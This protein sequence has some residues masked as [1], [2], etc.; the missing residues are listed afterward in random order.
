MNEHIERE[1]DYTKSY[2]RDIKRY[3][4]LSDVEEYNLGIAKDRGDA[5]ALDRFVRSNLKLVVNIARNYISS[6]M[7]LMDLVQEGNIGLLRAAQKYDYKKGCRFSTY[8]SYWIRHY[9]TRLI[10]KKGSMIRMPIRKRNLYKKIRKITA[11]LLGR[12]GRE[13]RI[14]DIAGMMQMD[15]NTIRKTMEMFR[16][17]VSLEHS[18][19]EN[20]FNL[21]DVVI[22]E[23]SQ[24][25]DERIYGTELRK[26][27][28][29]AMDS[30]MDNEKK[31]LKLRFGF[32]DDR[33]V[34]LQEIGNRFGLSA[35]TVRQVENRA[36]EK[37]KK[38]FSHLHDFLDS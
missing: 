6:G 15:E 33:P 17:T 4:L 28:E 12:L 23:N 32:D 20:G 13:P 38:N 27:L 7:S 1:E 9:I 26:E 8:A 3:K 18:M 37:I 24:A 25:P 11:H 36:M 30:L 22:D 35:E 14:S 21:K 2:Y 29:N 19:D 34:T 10:A 31:I 5:V 16:T